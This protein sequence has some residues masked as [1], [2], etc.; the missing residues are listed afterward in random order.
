[1]TE[2]S[3]FSTLGALLLFLIHLAVIA[4]VILRPHREPASRI[5][6]IVVII[7]LPVVG[8]I[9]YLL[10][11]ET[12]IGRRRVRRMRKCWPVC[13]VSP[14][15]RERMRQRCRR[16]FRNVTAPLFRVGHSVNGF[17]PVGGNHGRLLPDSNAT[18]ESIIADID[19][20][21]D[22]R[23]PDLLHLA[24]GQQRAQNGRSAETGRRATR[25]PAGPWPTGLGRGL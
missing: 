8:I 4:R 7:A 20:A 22:R 15:R 9:S 11:G 18:I 6:W 17:E 19:A 2:Y 21:K 16:K 5:A 25:S 12:N 10:L 13:R 23:A 1:M 24:A 14:T 3:F